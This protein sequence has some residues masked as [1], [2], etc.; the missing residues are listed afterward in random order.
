MLMGTVMVQIIEDLGRM[1][2]AVENSSMLNTKLLPGLYTS[3]SNVD[4]NWV[5]D[6]NNVF[7]TSHCAGCTV[8]GIDSSIVRNSNHPFLV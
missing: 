5:C 3:N 6:R 1:L 7:R 4:G 8:V 2:H